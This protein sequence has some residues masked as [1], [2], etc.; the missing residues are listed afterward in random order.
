MR[1]DDLRA[2]LEAARDEGLAAIAAAGD[3]AGVQEARIRTL[4]R[5]TALARARSSLGRVPDDERRE[6]GRLANEVQAALEQALAAKTAEFEAA[7]QA[8]R[9]ERDRIDVTLPGEHF[10]PGSIHPLTKTIWEIVDVFVGLGYALADG[11]EVE[12]STLNFDALNA[13]PEHPSR[14]PADTFYVEGTGERVLLRPQTSPAQIRVMES[15]PPP[16]YIVVPGRCY[17][18]D[19]EDATHLSSFTQVEGL[20]V[21][22]GITVADMKGTLEHVARALFGKDLATRLRGHF[23]PF[24]EPS[25]EMDVE[26]FVCRGSGCR[27]CKGEGWIELLGCGMVDP[28]LFEWVGYDP[29]RYSGFAFGLG[30]ERA[31]ALS[32]GVGDIRAL[33]ENDVRFLAQFEGAL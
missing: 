2:R 19:E 9:W 24:T 12:L 17:R 5:K 32:H 30:V 8:A 11:P 21:D 15:Q 29:E 3:L 20:A 27:V 13:P 31:A 25:A 10:E 28:A 7:E 18:R 22:E 14:S 1:D 16:V 23:F 6:L 33:Y 26:C 4:G